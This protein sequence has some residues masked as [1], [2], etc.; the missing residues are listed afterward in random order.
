M[1]TTLEREVKLRFAAPAEARAAMLATGATPFRARRLQEDCLLDTADGRL[2]GRRSILRVRMECGKSLI[3]FKGP[4]QPSVMKLRE[5]LETLGRRRSDADSHPRRARLRR[6]G[7]GTRSTARSSRS[8]TSSSRSTRRR[9][10]RSSRSKEANAASPPWRRRSAAQPTDYVL[11]SY[12]GL[13]ARLLRRSTVCRPADMLVL[14]DRPVAEAT[15]G[16]PPR[17]GPDGRARHPAAPADRSSAPS[18]RFRSPASRWSA[19]SSRGCRRTA[20]P[21]SC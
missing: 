3:T 14:N 16:K 9:S 2:R 1:T 7:S 18:R 21:I 4:A 20:S 15:G 10:A 12:R 5:E 13:F 6:R 8:T 19:A 11:D 17:A